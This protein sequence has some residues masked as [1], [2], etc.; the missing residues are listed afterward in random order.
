VFSGPGALCL[1]ASEGWGSGFVE[2]AVAEHREQDVDPLAGEPEEGLRVGL[3]SG[4]AL[5]AVGAGGIVQ[6]ASRRSGA[7]VT[8]LGDRSRHVR[9]A[10]PQLSPLTVGPDTLWGGRVTLAQR[11]AL[12]AGRDLPAWRFSNRHGATTLLP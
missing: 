11:P 8:V 2:G 7:P 6:G 1:W 12:P 4:S 3:S 10:G 9:L 5:V